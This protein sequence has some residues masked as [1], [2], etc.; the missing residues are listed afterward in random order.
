MTGTLPLLW[1]QGS[2]EDS[3]ISWWEQEVG[4]ETSQGGPFQQ[5]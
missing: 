3:A 5:E 4:L 1:T 2:L